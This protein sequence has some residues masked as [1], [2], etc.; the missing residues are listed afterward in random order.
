MSSGERTAVETSGI[1]DAPLQEVWAL[2]S[3][4]ANLAQW[5]LDVA[6]TH[7]E[8]GNGREAG[9]VRSLHLWNGGTIRE[10]L[11]AISPEEHFYTYALIE[12]PLP[13]RDHEST[14]R[15]S[16]MGNSQTQVTWAARFTLTEGDVGA[17]AE[18]VKSGVM[19]LGIE[20]LRRAVKK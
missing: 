10:R 15:L 4:F 7:L 8:S 2:V 17:F 9:A 13:I 5:H 14:V 18:A 1:V 12:S 20:G 19:E 3:D 11:L 6:E 16:P